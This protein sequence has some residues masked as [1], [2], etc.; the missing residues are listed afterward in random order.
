MA[1][2]GENGGSSFCFA[3]TVE[4][5]SLRETL[6]FSGLRFSFPFMCQC[7]ETKLFLWRHSW[8]SPALKPSSFLIRSPSSFT[9]ALCTAAFPRKLTPGRVTTSVWL[10]KLG[11][12]VKTYSG[13]KM[14]NQTIQMLLHF[15][16]DPNMRKFVWSPKSS[17]SWF[18]CIILLL[19]LVFT[20][21][22]Y[23]LKPLMCNPFESASCRSLYIDAVFSATINLTEHKALIK[24]LNTGLHDSTSLWAVTKLIAVWKIRDM[25]RLLKCTAQFLTRSCYK[26][27]QPT[28]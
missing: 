12:F 20:P 18:S 21:R 23:T 25:R 17:C 9:S 10:Q 7:A 27:L 19:P 15:T 24:M 5:K 13:L 14:L 1:R 3:H 22:Y 28:S 4:R 2:A 16:E 8:N 11:Q 26:K 6:L